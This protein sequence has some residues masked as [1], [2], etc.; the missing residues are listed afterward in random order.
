MNKY[1]KLI[2]LVKIFVTGSIITVLIMAAATF[3]AYLFDLT[4]VK[5]QLYYTLYIGFFLISFIV[6]QLFLIFRSNIFEFRDNY[7]KIMF[8]CLYILLILPILYLSLLF[9]YYT[10]SFIFG[11]DTSIRSICN[12]PALDF[13]NSLFFAGIP[14]IILGVAILL[15]SGFLYGPHVFRK[16]SERK[17]IY[18]KV[19]SA[20]YLGVAITLFYLLYIPSGPDEC[21]RTITDT[22][23]TACIEKQ[24]QGKSVKDAIEWFES[25]GHK[26]DYVF[27]DNIYE[28]YY[29]YHYNEIDE[30]KVGY[31]FYS[32]RFNRITYGTNFTRLLSPFPRNFMSFKIKVTEKENA[33]HTYQV[34]AKISGNY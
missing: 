22:Q 34:E 1:S 30:T 23:Y 6:C 5:N 18:R 2:S 33:S 4:V 17:V 10:F 20:S 28:H 9:L 32:Q 7:K 15:L 29:T 12:I 27:N 31:F 13:L 16:L 24:L 21:S 25:R 3:V 11:C 26:I 8:S 19:I 14:I